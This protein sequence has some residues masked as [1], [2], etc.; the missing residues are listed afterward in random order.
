[1]SANTSHILQ[2]LEV[3]PPPGAWDAISAQLDAEYDAAETVIAHKLYEAA[4][5]PPAAAWEQ[6]SLAINVAESNPATPAKVIRFPFYKVAVAAAL[7][8]VV[9]YVTWSFL[10]SNTD[11]V[12]QSGD[13]PVAPAAV[14]PTPNNDPEITAK[15]S[16]PAI[17]ASIAGSRRTTLNIAR[18]T[19]N[20]SIAQA[21]YI[22]GT[23]IPE[24]TDQD[25]RYTGT[26]DIHAVATTSRR[27]IKGPAIRDASGN[28]VMD[29]VLVTGGTNTYVIITC[30][31]G[32]QTR[33]SAKFLP[34]LNYMNSD[35]DPA[36]Y[37]DAMVRDNFL[38]KMRFHAWRSKLMQQADFVPTAGNFFDIIELKELLDEMPQ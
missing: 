19:I 27:G 18:R 15:P 9:S 23:D 10:G 4:I 24:A 11:T 7:L 29:Q 6:I 20:E 8:A 14:G 1:M 2:H 5:M 30:P 37:L 38:W 32:E 26:N 22:T 25:I 35:I 12:A 16:M 21:D 33:I 13:T 36:E 31:N 28:L 17:D 3:P 34:L